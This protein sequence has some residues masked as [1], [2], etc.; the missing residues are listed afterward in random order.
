MNKGFYREI[1][2][3]ILTGRIK[4]KQELHG[5]KI[6]L[7]RRHGIKKVPADSEIIKQL[8]NH[9]SNSDKELLLS[10]LRKKPVRTVS[11]V[12]VVAVM[13]S[14]ADCPHGRCIPCPGGPSGNTPQSYTGYEPAAMRAIMHGFDPYKQTRSRTEQLKMVGHPVDKIDFIVMGGTFTARDPFYQEWFIKRC[15]DGLNNSG[16]KNLREA[17]KKNETAK[18]R[19]IGLTIE[20]RPDWLRVQ[21]LDNALRFG[22]TRVELGVQTIFDTLL[23]KMRRGHTVTDIVIATRLAK[24]SGLKVCYH[25]MPGLPGSNLGMD[26]ESFKTIFE[27][28][29]FRPDML[30]IYPTLVVEGTE[31]HKQWRSGGYKPL[32][33]EEAV[34]LIASVKALVPEWVRIQRVERDV[35]ATR[36]EAGV[37][38]SNLRQLVQMEMRKQGRQCRCIRCREYGHV[39]N[40]RTWDDDVVVV[41]RQYQ[42]SDGVE[43][44]LSIEDRGFNVVFGYLRL[45]LPANPHR[46]ELTR[47]K[48]MVI[49]ELKVVGKEIPLGETGEQGVQHRGLGRE[50]LEEAERIS[51]EEFDCTR[52]F[53]L[54]GV[55]VKEYY[56]RLGFE[57]DGVYLSKKLVQ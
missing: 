53:V 28:Q 55:G 47:E 15:F 24:D 8:P 39:E 51:G 9:L 1:I 48:C 34:P 44:F 4:N 41:R 26:M 46:Y 38:A 33:E 30:K 27:D 18:S 6:K 23:Y 31:L 21:H 11:G 35:P 54:S 40:A 10:V 49:G 36:I 50:L 43:V 32:T 45:R 5:E 56:R 7:C 16:S 57:N 52:L 29:R 3:G 17:Q 14:P 12:T 20:T 37:K 13:T 42:A 22:C 19:C 2:N 25:M